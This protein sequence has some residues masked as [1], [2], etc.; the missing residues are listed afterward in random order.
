MDAAHVK[1]GMVV[2]VASDSGTVLAKRRMLKQRPQRT[3]AARRNALS[4]VTC[5][6]NVGSLGIC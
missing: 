6:P 1:G 5:P 2:V 3:R 4:I